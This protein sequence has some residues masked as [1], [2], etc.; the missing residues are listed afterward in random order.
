MKLY[1]KYGIIKYGRVSIMFRFSLKRI[2]SHCKANDMLFTKDTPKIKRLQ[3]KEAQMY[4]RRNS[5]Y[6][7]V[8]VYHVPGNFHIVVQLI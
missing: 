6:Q 1:L 7:A 8:G 3:E 4:Q 5:Y 2:D